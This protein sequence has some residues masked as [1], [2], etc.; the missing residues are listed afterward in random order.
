VAF[1]CGLAPPVSLQIQWAQK[2]WRAKSMAP[3]HTTKDIMQ[4]K[5]KFEKTF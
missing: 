5:Q 1:V 4:I 3:D 2:V